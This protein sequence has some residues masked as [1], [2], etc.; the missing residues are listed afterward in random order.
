MLCCAR[1]RRCESSR[2]TS[3]LGKPLSKAKSPTKNCWT[4]S[5][6]MKAVTAFR[7]VQNKTKWDKFTNTESKKRIPWVK[8]KSTKEALSFGKEMPQTPVQCSRILTFAVIKQY[9]TLNSYHLA[10]QDTRVCQVEL[11]GVRGPHG[12][13]FGQCKGPG[14]RFSKVPIIIGSGK[15][16]PFTLKIAVSIVLHLTW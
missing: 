11:K 10:W 13:T 14:A 9:W 8:K 4:I 1:N 15:L 16:S 5:Q 3:P 7:K 12:A 2:V 6:P